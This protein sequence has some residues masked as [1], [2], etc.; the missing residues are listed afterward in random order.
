MTSFDWTE[1]K[2]QAYRQ[3]LERRPRLEKF[4][5]EQVTVGISGTLT[6]HQ[7]ALAA[8]WRTLT[9]DEQARY[10]LEQEPIIIGSEPEESLSALGNEFGIPQNTL[11]K[12][13]YDGRLV[14]RRSGSVWLSTRTAVLEAISEGKIRAKEEPMKMKSEQT[15]QTYR[16]EVTFINK[17]GEQIK[18]TVTARHEFEASQLIRDKGAHIVSVTNLDL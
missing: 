17:N 9:A 1:E 2:E 18:R 13:A 6:E 4:D 11:Y 10:S 8:W 12:A 14:A 5:P 16:Y 3:K 15:T 7:Q